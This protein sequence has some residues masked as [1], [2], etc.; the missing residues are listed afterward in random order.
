MSDKPPKPMPVFRSMVSADF[1]TLA[2][3]GLGTAA[4]FLCLK[5]ATDPRDL[6]LWC[7]FVML[8]FALVCDF[9]DGYVARW[10]QK[11][12]LLG[13]DLDSL[14]DIISFGVAPAT[15][16]FTLGLNGFWDVIILIY[17]VVCGI[18]RLARFNVT[19]SEMADEAGKVK[20]YVG[21]PIPASIIIVLFMAGVFLAG[22]VEDDILFGVVR[23][24]PWSFHPLSVIYLLNG[25]AMISRTIKIPKPL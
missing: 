10:R 23:V 3:A 25:T 16:G 12:S 22:R 9:L 6:Y 5:Y 24:G 14:S 20:Y 2:N 19:S 13:A 7:V 15:L 17:F 21:M 11:H 4:I 8:P 18:G 1:I